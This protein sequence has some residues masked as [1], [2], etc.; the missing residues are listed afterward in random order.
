MLVHYQIFAYKDFVKILKHKKMVPCKS[1]D[2]EVSF[3]WSHHRI[4]ST[5]SKVRTM[6]HVF[7]INSSSERDKCL[8]QQKKLTAPISQLVNTKHPFGPPHSYAFCFI[9]SH[10]V[11]KSPPTPPSN[12]ISM[13]KTGDHYISR[14]QCLWLI[15]QDK[16][17][18]H[19]FSCTL[20][21]STLCVFM[22]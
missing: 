21:H 20:T 16:E 11:P 10:P 8:N 3:E 15:N 12:S 14:A 6:L 1:I 9:E 22:S 7:I 2:K 18:L 4:S 19:I 13:G 17:N 5:N